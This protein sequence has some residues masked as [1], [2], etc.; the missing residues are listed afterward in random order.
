MIFDSYILV[1]G[2]E[3]CQTAFFLICHASDL[4]KHASKQSSVFFF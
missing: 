3:T 2:Q 1:C 4:R